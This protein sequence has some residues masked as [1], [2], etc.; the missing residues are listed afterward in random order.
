VVLYS[1]EQKDSIERR[2][3]RTSLGDMWQMMNETL[4]APTLL[5]ALNNLLNQADNVATA[6]Q[7]HT[8]LN[9]VKGMMFGA[10]ITDA[11]ITRDTFKDV[12][13][14]IRELVKKAASLRSVELTGT[15]AGDNY[16][17]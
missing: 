10:Q 14:R 5:L 13:F 2:Q 11:S 7:I 8:L 16:G 6:S 4:N 17:Y 15:P 3:L 12:R 9:Y 1:E